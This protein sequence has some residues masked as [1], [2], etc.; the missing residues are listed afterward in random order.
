M[1]AAHPPRFRRRARDLVTQGD[2]VSPTAGDLGISESCLC[3]WRNG[4][5]VDAGRRAGVTIDEHKG[6]RRARH[7][8]RMLEIEIVARAAYSVR[9]NVLP[10]EGS[11]GWSRSS[12]RRDSRRGGL[13]VPEHLT[14]GLRRLGQWAAVGV[15]GRRR[16]AQLDDPSD[17]CRLIGNLRRAAGSRGAPARARDSLRTRRTAGRAGPGYRIVENGTAGSRRA[18][19]TRTSSKRQFTA[20]APTGGGSAATPSITREVAGLMRR[21]DRRVHP[22]DRGLV[23]LGQDHQGARRRRARDGPLATPPQTRDRGRRRQRS[24][25]HLLVFRSPAPLGR[26]PWLDGQNRLQRRQRIHRDLLVNNASASSS[27]PRTGTPGC[28]SRWRCSS[29]P[30]TLQLPPPAHIAR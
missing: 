21:R 27:T 14:A 23:D 18:S 26:S 11:S 6:T 4:D 29:G 3:N 5:A 20:D 28:N 9:G 12:P 2:L 1:P 16:G 24:A 7:S 19:G 10:E 8:N 15:S 13:P 17:P 22:P 30:R 25:V